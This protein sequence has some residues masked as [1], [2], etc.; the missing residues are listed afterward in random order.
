METNNISGQSTPSAIPKEVRGFNWGAF[1]FSWLW[2]LFNKTYVPLWG[3]VILVAEFV[4]RQYASIFSLAGLIFIIFCGIKGN[5]WGWKNKSWESIER[6]KKVQRR[7]GF[8][9]LIFIIACVAFP[10]AFLVFRVGSVSSQYPSSAIGN[11]PSLPSS[12]PAP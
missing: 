7:W 8:A 5:E 12:Y 6:F 10:L 11:I 2:G 3:L 9:F 1:G 4:F